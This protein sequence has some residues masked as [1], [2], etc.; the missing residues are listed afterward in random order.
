MCHPTARD[1]RKETVTI[2]IQKEIP[3]EQATLRG[4]GAFQLVTRSVRQ[5]G[6]DRTTKE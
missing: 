2:T 1:T 6:T 4:P 5:N 3:K